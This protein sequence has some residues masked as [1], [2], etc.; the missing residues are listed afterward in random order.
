MLLQFA[1]MCVSL[2]LHVHNRLRTT[3]VHFSVPIP[4][5]DAMWSLQREEETL[6]TVVSVPED[7]SQ[8]ALPFDSFICRELV[9]LAEQFHLM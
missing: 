9:E 7:I 8:M 1:P 2:Y 6:Q 4:R 3:S 5:Q